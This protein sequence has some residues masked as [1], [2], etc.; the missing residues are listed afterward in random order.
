MAIN[1]LTSPKIW[2]AEYDLSGDLSGTALT[3]SSELLDNTTFGD[4]TRSRAGGLKSVALSHEGLWN[5]G[6]DAIDDVLFG[7]IGVRNALASSAP[8]GGAVGNV[9]YFFRAIHGEY[10]PGAT[11][12]AMLRFS[13]SAEGS[14]GIGLVRGQLL[15]NNTLTSTGAGTGIQLGAASAGQSVYAAMHVLSSG[16]GTLDMVVESDA[17]NTFGS[18]TTRFTF[19]QASAATSEWATPVAGA[20]T[21]TWYR[22]SY[23]IAGASPSFEAVV[24]VGIK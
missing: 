1:V 21:D 6:D 15:E 24:V 20:V 4:T 3:L 2:L 12:G 13:V 19:T 22:V 14:D 18:A 5:G 16:T 8:E 23:T 7:K 9:A 11:V 10:S 17:D